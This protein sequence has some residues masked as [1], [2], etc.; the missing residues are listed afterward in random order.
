MVN[1]EEDQDVV[2]EVDTTASV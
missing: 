2:D 1:Q